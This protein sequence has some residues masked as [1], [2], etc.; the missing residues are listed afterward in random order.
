MGAIE[1]PVEGH[2]HVLIILLNYT[3]KKLF[4]NLK[5]ITLQSLHVYRLAYITF[6]KKMF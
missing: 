5:K 4:N 3:K 1:R 2:F 6:I